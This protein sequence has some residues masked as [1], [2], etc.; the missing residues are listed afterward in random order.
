[1]RNVCFGM[2][3]MRRDL[4]VHM[5]PG[6]PELVH[7]LIFRYCGFDDND[8]LRWDSSKSF[9]DVSSLHC[10]FLMLLEEVAVVLESSDTT[11][12]HHHSDYC[13]IATAL[14]PRSR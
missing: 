9:V 3:T 2:K 7:K 4:G 10:A 11:A 12:L 1:M 14:I 8:I 5:A 13:S 6:I